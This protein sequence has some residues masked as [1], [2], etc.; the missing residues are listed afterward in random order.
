MKSMGNRGHKRTET[1]D[2]LPADKRTCSSLEFRPSSSTSPVQTPT[3][4]VNQTHDHDM[5]TSSSASGSGRT[6]EDKDSAYGSCDSDEMGDA[7][8]IRNRH[9]IL[10]YQRQRLSG[11]QVKFKRVLSNLNEEIE[12]SAQQA[13]LMEL[14]EI[15]SFCTDSS[16]S[17]LMADSLSP[18]LIK[19]ARHESNPEIMLLSIRALTYLCDIYPRSAGFIVRHDGVTALCQ[20]LLAIEYVDVA[21]Q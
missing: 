9:A 8:H 19:L 16:L 11:D 21:E 1:V 6:D 18:I 3:T 4:S 14:C 7:E 17:S 15:L 10:D 12:E 13:A 5:E 2:E 20:R